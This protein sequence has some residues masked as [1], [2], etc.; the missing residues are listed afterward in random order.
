ML[1]ERCSQ[2]LALPDALGARW[3]FRWFRGC[4][5]CDDDLRQTAE[6]RCGPFF[7]PTYSLTLLLATGSCI[8][9]PASKQF[10]SCASNSIGMLWAALPA[11][12]VSGNVVQGPLGWIFP[13]RAE[14]KP[15]GLGEKKKKEHRLPRTMAQ[16]INCLR[17][18]MALQVLCRAHWR[19]GPGEK[20][21][22]AQAARM[23]VYPDSS[24]HLPGAKKN[25]SAF[26]AGLGHPRLKQTW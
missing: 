23:A 22:G 3:N 17:N 18:E 21:G 10:K 7:S 6:G 1:L 11:F 2:A 9:V 19:W 12:P 5:H 4:F 15:N 13:E 8:L 24:G 14:M 16:L 26:G 25:K 20:N